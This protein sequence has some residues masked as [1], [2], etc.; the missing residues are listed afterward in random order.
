MDHL[1]DFEPAAALHL[2]NVAVERPR[3]KALREQVERELIFS[4]CRVRYDEAPPR[5]C[6]LHGAVQFESDV[7]LG[8]AAGASLCHSGE[9]VVEPGELRPG[10][11]ARLA[12]GR[13]DK[14]TG[15]P[16]APHVDM[17]RHMRQPALPCAGWWTRKRPAIRRVS[18]G[19]FRGRVIAYQRYYAQVTEE[20]RHRRERESDTKRAQALDGKLEAARSERERKLR[21]LG[22]HH[23]LRR[24][25]QLTSARLLSQPKTFF[26]VL[27]DPGA[28]DAH[29]DP[30]LRL[31]VGAA[32]AA[33]VR[34]LPQ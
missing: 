31:P 12:A 27:L 24:R 33:G 8:R 17:A 34:I 28:G 5:A 21:E 25:A 22:E 7:P 16:E 2:G 18:G 20:L 9:L 29:P 1:L 23:R 30:V 13:P 10:G 26:R 4:H 19:G 32:G 11:V 6:V 14:Q 3:T 15:L